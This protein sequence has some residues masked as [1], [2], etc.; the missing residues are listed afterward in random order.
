VKTPVGSITNS[1]IQGDVFGPILCSK[2]VE[3][4]GKECLENHKFTDI[5]KNEVE[6]P[7]LSMV[8]DVI[9]ISECGFHI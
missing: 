3:T 7:P 9:C 2:Q 5:Y 6:I 1:I 8:D 4:F